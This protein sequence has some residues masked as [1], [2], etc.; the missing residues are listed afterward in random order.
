MS[1]INIVISKRKTTATCPPQCEDM[2]HSRRQSHQKPTLP[3][4]DLGIGLQ[5][6]KDESLMFKPKDGMLRDSSLGRDP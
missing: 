2:W 3:N 6:S 1:G 5:N 4:L